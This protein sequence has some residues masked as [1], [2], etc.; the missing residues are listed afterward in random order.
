MWILDLRVNFQHSKSFEISHYNSC[1]RH[2]VYSE[3]QHG[4]RS[5]ATFM[6]IITVGGDCLSI[7]LATSIWLSVG[8]K[9]ADS[10][11][12]PCRNNWI[13]V[14]VSFMNFR[15]AIRKYF[16]LNLC[17]I[18][19]V[20]LI[21]LN[22]FLPLSTIINTT[23][24]LDNHWKIRNIELLKVNFWKIN[25]SSAL[26]SAVVWSLEPLQMPKCTDKQIHSLGHPAFQM[27]SEGVLRAREP[28]PSEGLLRPPEGIKMFSGRPSTQKPGVMF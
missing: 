7:N 26:G 9:S 15:E 19:N 24:F 11:L 25:T 8:P 3:R 21:R 20:F 1:F 10:P 13:V 28:Q 22:P 23:T 27:W 2:P 5:S 14:L 6:T 17:G 4:Q 16:W 18:K 12:I